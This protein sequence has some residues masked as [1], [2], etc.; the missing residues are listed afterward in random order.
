MPDLFEKVELIRYEGKP[1]KTTEN[2]VKES[3]LA[4]NINGEW[5]FDL[6][7]FLGKQQKELIAGHLFAR[8]MIHRAEDIVS[9]EIEEKIAEVELK[10]L[11]SPAVTKKPIASALK[12]KPE[13]V[14]RCVRAVLKSDIF[15][16]TEGVHCAGLFLNGKELACI[17][18][19]VGRHHT[20]DKVIGAALLQGVPL[21]EC[22]MAA[23]GRM[24]AEMVTKICRAG[25]PIVATKT[26]VT[27]GGLALA[28]EYGLTLIGFVR[29][30]GSKMNTD[31]STRTFNQSVMKIYNG[32][33]RL[34][35]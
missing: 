25:I 8:G 23:T 32:G 20:M 14:F 34:V 16:E 29:E 1:E 17:A 33:A 6:T 28:R 24:A 26:A 13:D 35:F 11:M 19:D 4:V 12:V 30:A 2:V 22:L 10:K 31:M 18:E 9:I 7:G 5:V 15:A 3:T 27:G 21:G